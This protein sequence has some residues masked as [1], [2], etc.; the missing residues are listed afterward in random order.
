MLDFYH[1]QLDTI[2]ASALLSGRPKGTY[3]LRQRTKNKGVRQ[4]VASFVRENGRTAHALI[5]LSNPNG[6]GGYV[7][8]MGSEKVSVCFFSF[9]FAFCFVLICFALILI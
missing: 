4:F 2:G 3:L 5:E 9:L 6:Q 7:T 1:F 8:A